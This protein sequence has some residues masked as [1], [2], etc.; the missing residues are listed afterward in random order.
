MFTINNNDYISISRGNRTT[1][2]KIKSY[3]KYLELYKK[4]YGYSV[5]FN[6]LESLICP[7]ILNDYYNVHLDKCN[8]KIIE[9]NNIDED[10]I[11]LD[12][13]EDL[14]ITDSII[15]YPII[16]HK[17]NNSNTR[18]QEIKLSNSIIDTL[19]INDCKKELILCNDSIIRN[20]VVFESNMMLDVGEGDSNQ[21]KNLYTT[22]SIIKD[23]SEVSSISLKAEKYG[24]NIDNIY[25]IESLY[26]KNNYSGCNLRK[27]ILKHKEYDNKDN[28]AIMP[29][30]YYKGNLDNCDSDLC[31]KMKS[32]MTEVRMYKEGVEAGY[33]TRY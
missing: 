8:M 1:F 23:F 11:Y 13:I 7:L 31:F 26:L 32:M 28:N 15:E 27:E 18:Y 2:K 25:S 10:C 12:E 17:N 30:T 14:E 22:K 5:E 33:D 20:L 4:T 16:N 9:N 21:I 29:Y 24:L 6:E 19:V 3:Y